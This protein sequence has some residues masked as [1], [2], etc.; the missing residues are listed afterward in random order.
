[1]AD[2]VRI[3][4]P[5]WPDWL[6]GYD[7]MLSRYSTSDGEYVEPPDVLVVHSGAIGENVAEYLAKPDLSRYV[8]SHFSWAGK[9][10]RFV[11]QVPLSHIAWHCRGLNGRSIGVELSGPYTQD[12]R[13]ETERLQLRGL[14]VTVQAA[15][16]GNLKWWCRHSEWSDSKRDPGPGMLD[17]WLDGLGMVHRVQY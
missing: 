2:P 11:Q 3:W 12:P 8:S 15:T 13:R 4:P 9:Q 1:M 5:E 16:M 7:R 6:P 10:D 14:V 17:S